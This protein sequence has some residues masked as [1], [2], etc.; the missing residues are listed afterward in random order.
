MENVILLE[1]KNKVAK[2]ESV[3]RVRKMGSDMIFDLVIGFE[4]FPPL[5]LPLPHFFKFVYFPFYV[6]PSHIIHLSLLISSFY[7][8]IC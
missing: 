1:G 2:R 5:T 7:T 3:E 4:F 8:L 6:F